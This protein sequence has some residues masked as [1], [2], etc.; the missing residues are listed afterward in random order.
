MRNVPR[1]HLDH[2]PPIW[3]RSEADFFV[4]VCADPRG[5]NHFCNPA[6]G[7]VILESIQNRHNREVWFCHLAVLMPDHIHLLL[8]FPGDKSLSRIVGEWKG[9][10]GRHKGISWQRNFFDHRLRNEE[11]DRN[12]ADYVINN[13]VRAGLVDKPEDWPYSWMPESI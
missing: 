2:V 9:W 3:V 8:N 12:K 13:P 11:Q 1:K 10:L 7:P 5:I 4:T 6:I